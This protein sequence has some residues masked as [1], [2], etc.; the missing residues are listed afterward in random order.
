[1][2]ISFTNCDVKHLFTFV[3][4]PININKG[5]SQITNKRKRERLEHTEWFA[6]LN[7]TKRLMLL[8]E[9]ELEWTGRKILNKIH[10]YS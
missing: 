7:S 9:S 8:C 6:A 10:I 2:Y 3:E 4:L 1:M 5:S